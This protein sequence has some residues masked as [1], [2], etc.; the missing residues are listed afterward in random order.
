MVIS[1]A[2]KINNRLTVSLDKRIHKLLCDLMERERIY[3][4][5]EYIRHLILKRAKDCGVIDDGRKYT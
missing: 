1:L 4:T 3:V 5:S 2:V